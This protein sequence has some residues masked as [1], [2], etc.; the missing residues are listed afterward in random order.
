PYPYSQFEK[1]CKTLD[2]L[3]GRNFLADRA[4]LPV[5]LPKPFSS[6]VI[7]STAWFGDFETSTTSCPIYF[8]DDVPNIKV[9]FSKPFEKLNGIQV[10]VNT[11]DHKPP[12]IHAR[13][14]NTQEVRR[15]EWP[16]LAPLK[17]D[18]Q[19]R[20][21]TEDAVRVYAKTYWTEISKKVAQVPW[22]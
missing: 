7:S 15:F 22:Q 12:H 17:Q 16:S 11:R 19:I 21:P 18:V 5:W 1:F 4:F 10:F 2:F 6:E 3:D 8:K 13:D 9:V 20:T 14:L